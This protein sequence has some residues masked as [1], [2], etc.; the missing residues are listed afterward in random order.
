MN[1]NKA[2]PSGGA[3]FVNHTSIPISATGYFSPYSAG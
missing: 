3:F 1:E 2:L